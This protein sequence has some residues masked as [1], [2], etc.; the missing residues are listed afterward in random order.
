MI[1][2]A[3]A[4]IRRI[5]AHA[6]FADQNYLVSFVFLG[7]YEVVTREPWYRIEADNEKAKEFLGHPTYQNQMDK[8]NEQIPSGTL[9]CSPI[10]D[11][12][13]QRAGRMQCNVGSF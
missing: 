11:H 6:Y 10:P 13:Y 12:G 9:S 3:S 4:T 2:R 8:G 5:R 1:I 7:L